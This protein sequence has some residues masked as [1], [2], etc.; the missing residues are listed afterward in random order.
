MPD[1]PGGTGYVDLHCHLLWGVDDGAKSLA[2]SLAMAR[3]LVELGYSDAAPSPHNRAEYAPKSLALERLGEVQQALDAER[4]P[5]RL[6]ENSENFF[7][8]EHLLGKGESSSRRCVG[9]G[10]YLLVEAPY[11]AP[12]PALPQL[13]FRLKLLGVTPLIAHPERCLEF[14]RSSRARELVDAGARLQLDVG[15]VIGRYGPP[16]RKVAERLLDE[17]LYAVAATDLHAPTGA[18]DW[19]SRSFAVLRDRVGD[20]ELTQLLSERPRR[21]LSGLPLE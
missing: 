1:A 12:L 21:I 7:L 3:T 18:L 5:L 17:R 19:L 6:H 15:A 2:D 14:E 16:A 13:V 9:N 11:H 10:R 20:Q 4:I 8:D